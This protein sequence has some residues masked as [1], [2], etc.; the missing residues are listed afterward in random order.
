MFI[1]ETMPTLFHIPFPPMIGSKMTK[2]WKLAENSKANLDNWKFNFA[3]RIF[4][5]EALKTKKISG[6][7]LDV[8]TNYKEDN[9]LLKF[10][11]VVLSPRSAFFTAEALNNCAN[12]IV[13]DIK[14]FI[15]NNPINIIN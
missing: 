10:D 13:E 14:A 1:K 6:A 11:N 15:N 2:M 3:K 5:I 4:N 12:I 7:G 8:I 9:E